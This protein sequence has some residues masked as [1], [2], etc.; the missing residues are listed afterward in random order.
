VKGTLVCDTNGS[1]GGGNSELVDTPTVPLS[2]Q[3]EANFSG[4]VGPLPAVCLT[5]PD[6]AFLIRGASG[7]WF[8]AG[9]VREP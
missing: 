1:A 5:Q 9:I 7:S 3:G 8:A 6:I 2:L 4:N